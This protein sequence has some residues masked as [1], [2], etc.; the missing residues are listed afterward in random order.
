M[1]GDDEDDSPQDF[2]ECVS[3]EH[4]QSAVTKAVTN[5]LIGLKLGN[6]LESLD[7]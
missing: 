2:A 1:P 7:K 3:Q 4:L 5:A 6:A